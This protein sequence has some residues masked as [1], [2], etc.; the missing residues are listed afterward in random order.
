MFIG[1]DVKTRL[2]CVECKTAMTEKASM[3]IKAD[4]INKLK[5]EAFATG[6]PYWTLAFNFGLENGENFYIISESLFRQLQEHL[7]EE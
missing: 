3:S 1:G 5:E 6:K 2:F 4:W 7:E